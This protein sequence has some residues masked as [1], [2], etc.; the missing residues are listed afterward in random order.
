MLSPS[1]SLQYQK[2]S[3]ERALPPSRPKRVVTSSIFPFKPS[4]PDNTE[5][6]TWHVKQVLSQGVMS[7]F[8][9]RLA[10]RKYNLPPALTSDSA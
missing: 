7:S 2:E 4:F 3:V 9:T 1:Q 5:I 6:K 8:I 10:A